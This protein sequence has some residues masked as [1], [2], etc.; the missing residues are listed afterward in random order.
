[1]ARER[2]Q[3]S[4]SLAP[5]SLDI[6]QPSRERSHSIGSLGRS[7]EI[8]QPPA[9]RCQTLKST[10]HLSWDARTM[11]FPAITAAR[12][13]SIL[14]DL[15]ALQQ[16]L[17]LGEGSVKMANTEHKLLLNIDAAEN[18][19]VTVLS[20]Q[21]PRRQLL[22]DIFGGD[23]KRIARVWAMLNSL[24]AFPRLAQDSRVKACYKVALSVESLLQKERTLSVSAKLRSGE[25][26]LK[27]FSTRGL[28][29]LHSE[30]SRTE[31]GHDLSDPME[32]RSQDHF[33]DIKTT[34]AVPF[35]EERIATR[36]LHCRSQGSFKNASPGRPSPSWFEQMRV[37]WCC[38]R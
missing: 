4:I 12:V 22:Q 2:C 37:L 23:S 1:M 21:D 30:A 6:P 16:Q 10:R 8:P 26:V 36:L 34:V 5:R 14:S 24:T 18:L 35:P 32:E 25:A 33:K 15:E 27:R 28:M 11:D 9:P 29:K 13:D 20:A 38:S 19:M 17:L 7:L 31:V 3:S